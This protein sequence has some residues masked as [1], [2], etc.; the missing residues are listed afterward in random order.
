MFDRKNVLITGAAG[1][2]GHALV[3]E[4]L[5]RGANVRA[6]VNNR[7]LCV[8]DPKLQIVKHDLSNYSEC[9][10]ACKDMDIVLNCVA[11]I[12]GAL[13]Q[14]EHPMS[15]IRSNLI[16]SVNMIEAA[17]EQKVS[18]FGFIGSSTM[19]PNVS[20]PVTESEG[21][22]GDPAECY[23][24]VG[25]MKRYCEKL[26][27][28]FHKISKTKFA[29]IRTTAIYGPHDSLDTNSSHVIPSLIVKVLNRQDPFEVWGDGNQV[30]DFVYV[31]DLVNG[32]LKCVENYAVADPINI[33]SGQGT[34]I[35]DMLQHLFVSESFFPN[36]VY[37]NDKPI[38]IP[39][40][41]VSIEKAKEVLDYKSRYSLQSGLQETLGWYKQQCQK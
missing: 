37:K 34:T 30:R 11:F 23:E 26:C 28:Y 9:L 22:I 25:W 8:T 40:R 24:G 21:F 36:V 13:G 16:P 38:M 5:N 6:V 33:S 14:S 12:R 7:N 15:L 39:V 10:Q 19:Y 27:M 32:F 41:L 20:Y 29:M 1:L 17:C 4:A 31:D 3:K 18:R 35:K 2:V